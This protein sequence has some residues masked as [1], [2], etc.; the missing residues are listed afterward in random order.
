M[1]TNITDTF[2]LSNGNK[3]PCLGF[4][5]WIPDISQAERVINDALEAGYRLF[6][7]ASQYGSERTLG[8]VLKD[9]GVKRDEV[10]LSSKMWMDE[11]GYKETKEALERSMDRLQVDYLDMY[12]IH[13]PRHPE[14][15]TYWPRYPKEDGHANWKELDLE[16]W[17]ALEEAYEEG[18]I[19]NIGVSNFMPHH[20][21]NIVDNCRIRPV[22]NQMEMHTLY[23]QEYALEYCRKENIFVEASAP[24]GRMRAFENSFISAMAE[25]YHVT[26]AQLCI[27]YLLQRGLTPLPKSTNTQRIFNNAD[28]FGFEIE[29]EDMHML[30]CLPSNGGINEHPDVAIPNIP[31]PK[32]Q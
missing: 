18:K 30:T 14:N 8:K 24:L 7:T 9:N 10:F 12:L 21:E 28:V 27:R 11:M 20:L 5:T 19:K 13:W 17:R 4:G 26:V 15:Y 22:V 6:D 25:K 32:D 3:I 23:M 1:I 16:T 31:S 2:T 29:H